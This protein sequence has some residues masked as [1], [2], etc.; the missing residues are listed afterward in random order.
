MKRKTILVCGGSYGLGFYIANK[1][2]NQGQRVIIIS[3][4]K[5]NLN[6]AK[7][8]INSNKADYY[9]CDCSIE[10]KVINLMKKL[11]KKYKSID[12]VI[13]NAGDSNMAKTGNEDHSVWLRAFSHNFFL[14][15]NIVEAY[16]KYFKSNKIKKIILISSIA[17]Y[18]KGNAPLSYSLAKQTLNKYCENISF[19]LSNY[20]ININTVSP[21][22]IL[23]KNNLWDK[24][25]KKNKSQIIKL[26]KNNVGL[27][28]FCLPEDIMNVINFLSSDKSN[29]LTGADIKVD[30][31]TL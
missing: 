25:M 22:H 19:Y 24:K 4:K 26:I 17:A 18:F 28:R 12:I 21:G 23:Q 2:V 20:K 15:T 16:K 29:Y 7:S 31:K 13:S 27:K 9:I 3:R 5:K 8:Q 11:K 6:K 10:K 14:H 30:G 1:F